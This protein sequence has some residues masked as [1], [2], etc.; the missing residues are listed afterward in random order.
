[1]LG[2]AASLEVTSITHDET[3]SI[4][5]LVNIW[6]AQHALELKYLRMHPRQSQTASIQSVNGSAGYSAARAGTDREP[7]EIAAYSWMMNRQKLTVK[8]A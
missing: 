8:D 5:S 1:M 3:R 7:V 6:H 4:Y 2:R